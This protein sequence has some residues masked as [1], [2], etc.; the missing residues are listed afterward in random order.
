MFTVMRR[1]Y[2]KVSVGLMEATKVLSYDAGKE[3]QQLRDLPEK[4]QS[5][6]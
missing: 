1:T 6:A 3:A 5:G 2:T 4:E